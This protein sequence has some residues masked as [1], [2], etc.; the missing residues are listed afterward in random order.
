VDDDEVARRGFVDILSGDP[1]VGSVVA[2]SHDVATRW[3]DEWTGVDVVL[4]DAVDEGRDDDQFP[5]VRVVE[6]VRAM[7]CRQPT[8]I[9]LTPYFSDDALRRRMREARADYFCRRAELGRADRLLDAV[10]G[11]GLRQRAVPGPIDLETQFRHGVTDATRV[12]RGVS[13][14]LVHRLP[15][16]LAQRPSPRSRMWLRLR[17]EFND[18]ARL[19]PVTADGRLPDRQQ[20]LP[21]L[22]QIARFL[23]WAT[24]PKAAL[25]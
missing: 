11:S 17:Q 1:R 21:S 25:V 15:E 14:A 23:D 19:S 4:V 7:A 22:P 9:V 5:G 10:C 16:L 24:R 8:V 13:F 20:D 12:N 6:Q 3:R 2:A 18:E